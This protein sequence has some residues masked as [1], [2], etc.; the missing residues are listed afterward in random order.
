MGNVIEPSAFRTF[1][2]SN[3]QIR[4]LKLYLSADCLNLECIEHVQSLEKCF[5]AFTPTAYQKDV[6][7]QTTFTSLYKGL[8]RIDSFRALYLGFDSFYHDAI[9]DL[10]WLKVLYVLPL[11]NYCDDAGWKDRLR[12]LATHMTHL[13]ESFFHT[14]FINDDTMLEFISKCNHLKVI[15]VM[16]INRDF[17]QR[18]VR[19]CVQLNRNIQIM[20]RGDPHE[21]SELD[22]LYKIHKNC[23][24]IQ[25]CT[26]YKHFYEFP[27]AA[28]LRT[29]E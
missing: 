4:Q 15:N 28:V 16:T 12:L 2:K 18:L 7:R 14:H 9:A 11:Y 19:L 17:Y 8:G 26:L 27:E 20:F 10:K 6:S 23:V 13:S 24:T 5:I 21:L 25:E 3:P 22:D 1:F 29:I